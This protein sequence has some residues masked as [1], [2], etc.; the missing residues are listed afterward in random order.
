MSSYKNNAKLIGFFGRINYALNDKYLLMA[1]LRYEGSSKFGANYKWGTFPAVSVGWRINKE[2]FMRG[3]TAVNDLK[4]RV[5]F[6]ITG[7]VP[8]DPYQSLISL[9]YEDRFLYNGTWI[10]G[11]APV[12]NPN[13]DLRWEKKKEYNFGLD[14]AL[15][16]N[17]LSGSI[18]VY[19]RDTKDM[20]YDFP[21]PVPPNLYGSTLANAGQMRNKGIEVLLN[22][23]AIRTRNFSFSNN[24]TYSNNK[25]TL[26]AISNDL[27]KTTNDFFEAGYTGEPIQEATHRVQVGQPIGNFYGY[28]SIDIDN[29]G[30]WIIE[31]ADGKPKKIADSDPSDKKVLGNGIP[32]H[33]VSW[34]LSFQ[35]KKVDLAINMRG[36][37][38]YQILN[39]QR[40]FFENPKIV[41]YNL[42]ASAF[43]NVYGKRR[44]DNDLAYVSYYIENGDHWKIDNITLGYN[45]G[46][47]NTKYLKSARVYASGL[48]LL[49]LTGYKG[50]DPEVSRQGLDA[51]N[52]LRDKY[53]TTRTYTVGVNLNF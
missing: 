1:S 15:L 4:L 6:G 29:D 51:G 36:A 47:K 2:S 8:T 18:D 16:K 13:P 49:V 31:G 33:T 30:K 28:K 40:L 12:R 25:N 35:Y 9:N 39:F 10:Q 19:Q 21:V 22:Y 11:I 32:K 50:I 38:G 48:N 14:F 5:G 42:L 45:I 43:D 27:Y 53:P 37:F 7:T 46:I 23:E 44:L 17:K 24:I 20:L 26:V 3:I 52:D 34:N 41:Q